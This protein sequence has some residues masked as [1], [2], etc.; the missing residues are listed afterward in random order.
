MVLVGGAPGTAAAQVA[1]E[2]AL[3]SDYRLR[4][5]SVS[6][7][8]PTASVSL[9]YDHPSGAYVG[10]LATATFRDGDPELLLLEGHAGYA[11]RIAP[12]VSLDG[13][14][15]HSQYY[16]GYGTNRNYQYTE[17]YVGG[18]VRNISGRLSYSPNYFF[19]DTPT[20]YAEINGGIEAAPNLFLSA[21]AGGLFYLD[22]AP[23]YLP[24]TRYD[25][26]L[27]VSRQF[28]PYG[29]HAELSGRIQ[30]E[31]SAVAHDK[32]AAAVA[33]TRAF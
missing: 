11:L 28:G 3:Q 31:G 7:G 25:W 23:Y 2:A 8:Q 5:Y 30:G 1:I 33:L 17:V 10:G 15:T 4:G 14:I 13:G 26:R 32:A 18:A 6:D 22:D 21:H 27:G 12:D 9:G 29:I 19:A 16:S 24:D 20:L